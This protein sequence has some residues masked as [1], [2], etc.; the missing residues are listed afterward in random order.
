MI[1]F[2]RVFE[3]DPKNRLIYDHMFAQFLAAKDKIRPVFHNLNKS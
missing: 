1:Q 2:D 3:P